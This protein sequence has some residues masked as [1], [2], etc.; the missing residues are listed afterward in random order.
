MNP[1]ISSIVNLTS[2]VDRHLALADKTS[3]ELA[4]STYEFSIISAHSWTTTIKDT[5]GNTT[6]VMSF[7]VTED[8]QTLTITH[9]LYGDYT[10][11]CAKDANPLPME[12]HHP[13]NNLLVQ[14]RLLDIDPLWC[15]ND[16]IIVKR[17]GDVI[18][19]WIDNISAEVT[20]S[21]N[22]QVN[23]NAVRELWEKHSGLFDA[24]LAM[25][26]YLFDNHNQRLEFAHTI[27]IL[28]RFTDNF[29]QA[30]HVLNHVM[31]NLYQL[32]STPV[33]MGFADDGSFERYI[34]D[35]DEAVAED[36][37]TVFVMPGEAGQAQQLQRRIDDARAMRHHRN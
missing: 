14:A 5:G 19:E 17:D 6:C 2:E 12:F 32:K 29:I 10:F 21:G 34:Y 18:D 15:N 30:T 31:N 26:N 27:A 23:E 3:K 35:E 25:S 22:G 28:G 16:T 13:I 33:A 7:Y 8:K 37:L 9:T 20:S 24:V 11:T 4:N 1:V 36:T